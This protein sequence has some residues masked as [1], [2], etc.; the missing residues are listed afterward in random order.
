MHPFSLQVYPSQWVAGTTYPKPGVAAA[1]ITNGH[2]E[3]VDSGRVDD[4]Q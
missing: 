1:G 3:D 2:L 4:G